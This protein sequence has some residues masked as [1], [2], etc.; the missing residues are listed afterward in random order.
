M[1][2]LE[3]ISHCDYMK[4][5]FTLEQNHSKPNGFILIWRDRRRV[6]HYTNVQKRKL[7]REVK[8][9]YNFT[10]EEVKEFM[11][12]RLKNIDVYGEYQPEV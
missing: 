9:Y 10:N 8:N 12:K 7:E 2:I 5:P 4:L 6:V 3:I 11:L 1:S